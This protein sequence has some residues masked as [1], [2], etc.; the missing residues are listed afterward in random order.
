MEMPMELYA[1]VGM[2]QILCLSCQSA[3]RHEGIL[4]PEREFDG[5]VSGDGFAPGPSFPRRRESS[6]R[7]DVEVENLA[8]SQQESTPTVS[9]DGFASDR[10]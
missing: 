7:G 8:H 2:S 4:L 1:P 3:T 6:V 5:E 9:S 10:K